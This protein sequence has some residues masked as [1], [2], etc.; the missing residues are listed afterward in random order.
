MRYVN[1]YIVYYNNYKHPTRT[2]IF[3]RIIYAYNKQNTIKIQ[4][5]C[6]PTH[7]QYIFC[8]IRDML[9]YFY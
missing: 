3:I 5:M 1:Y 9:N 7:I 8:T 4:V 6:I 2:S